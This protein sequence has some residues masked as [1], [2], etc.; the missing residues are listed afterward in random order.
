[1]K[2][3]YSKWPLESCTHKDK[4]STFVSESVFRHISVSGK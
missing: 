4:H 2:K 3:I 1:M